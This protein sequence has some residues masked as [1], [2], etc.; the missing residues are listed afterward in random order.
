MGFSGHSA[1]AED[2]M[3]EPEAR[4][5]RRERQRVREGLAAPVVVAQ[6]S[7]RRRRMLAESDEQERSLPR[8]SRGHLR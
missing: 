2:A 6:S 7:R 4:A 3:P 5:I 8:V 1:G